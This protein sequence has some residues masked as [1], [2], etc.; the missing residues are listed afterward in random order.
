LFPTLVGFLAG[1]WGL[2]GAMVIGAVAYGL[3]V[4]AFSAYPRPAGA[5]F[6]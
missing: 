2:G 3:A 5:K 6:L 1:S 4:L